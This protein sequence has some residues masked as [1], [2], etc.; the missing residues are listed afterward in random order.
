MEYFTVEEFAQKIKMSEYT[1]RKSIRE[2]WIYAIRPS[3]GKKSPYRIPESELER[4]QIL[5]MCKSNKE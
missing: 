3:N 2:K 1:V 5:S 4:L